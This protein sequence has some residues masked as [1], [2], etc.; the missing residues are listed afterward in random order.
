MGLMHPTS[1]SDWQRWQDRKRSAHRLAARIRG[2]GEGQPTTFHLYRRGADP[3]VVSVVDATSPTKLNAVIA[4]LAHLP[5]L[6]A[7]VLSSVDLAGRLPGEGW[8]H[9][10]VDAKAVPDALG[11]RAIGLSVG[12]YL[13]AG[14]AAFQWARGAGVPLAIVQHG[15]V[16]P[17]AP[18]LPEGSILLAWSDADADYLMARR[19]DV[20][21]HVVGSQLLWEAAQ[22]PAN[23]TSSE[24][25]P[26]YLGQLHGAELP[27]LGMT[28]R[29][30]EFCLRH[31]AVY[32]PHPAEKDALSR[33]THAL[34]RRLGIAFDDVTKPLNEVQRPV[35]AAFS[36]GLLEAA[37]R[38]Q[39]AWAYYPRPPRWLSEFWERYGIHRWGE[40]PTPAPHLPDTQPAAQVA[41]WVTDQ[42]TPSR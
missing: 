12:H 20:T 10:T 36:T 42:I 35:V 21:A 8:Q 5:E 15:L 38:G 23:C 40:S 29:T 39:Q 18:P 27:R 34:W 2:R 24:L 4:P 9:T 28:V 11:T 32:R 41:Q 19:T 17:F 6:D 33:A 37:V 30:T 7:A 3:R 1:L 26:V 13:A 25:A 31:G 16:T 14:Q 22:Q